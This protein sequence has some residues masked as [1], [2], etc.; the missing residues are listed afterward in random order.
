MSRRIGVGRKAEVFAVLVAAVVAL[1]TV[2]NWQ[3]GMLERYLIYFP[4]RT[5]AGNPSDL[6]MAHEDASFL[7]SDGVRLH[8]WFVPGEN[9]I[10]WL[11]FMATPGTSA[12]GWR[13]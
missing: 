9:E 4:G 1:F 10:T 6:G 12:T 5:L 2:L 8:G 3:T 7:A 13:T 11:W